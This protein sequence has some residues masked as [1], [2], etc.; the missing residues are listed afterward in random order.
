MFD[1]CLYNCIKAEN[2]MLKEGEVEMDRAKEDSSGG[3]VDGGASSGQV[4][5][6]GNMS[7]GSA[8]G[9]LWEQ[10]PAKKRRDR[11]LHAW[12]LGKGQI[13]L[14]MMELGTSQAGCSSLIL[15]INACVKF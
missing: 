12:Y 6:E 13:L 4:T 8:E 5:G 11:L 10:Q 2:T 9:D 1:K 7:N 15:L 14:K 3:N